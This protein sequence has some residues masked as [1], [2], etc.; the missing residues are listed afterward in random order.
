[1]KTIISTITAPPCGLP[2]HAI[3]SERD[4]LNTEDPPATILMTPFG[5][6]RFLETSGLFAAQGTYT[7]DTGALWVKINQR[8]H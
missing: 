2:S 3:P 1:M 4:G 5:N 7:L 8:G 6:R